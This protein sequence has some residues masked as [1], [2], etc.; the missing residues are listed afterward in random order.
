MTLVLSDN[1]TIVW[2]AWTSQEPTLAALQ[3]PIPGTSLDSRLTHSSKTFTRKSK[4]KPQSWL[5]SK[6]L[7]DNENPGSA[8]T[9]IFNAR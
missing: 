9:L 4:L 6:N 7:S 2:A 3:L 5:S 1:V 8:T